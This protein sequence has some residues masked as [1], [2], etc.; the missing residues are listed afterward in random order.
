V[1]AGALVTPLGSAGR[2]RLWNAPFALISGVLLALAE[3]LLH[4]TILLVFFVSQLTDSL[5]TIG[6]VVTVGLLGWYLP[7][8][9]VPWLSQSSARQMPWALSASLVRAAAAIFLAYSGYR[10]DVTDDDRLRS[11]FICYIVY[12]VAAGFAQSPVNELIA[13]SIPAESRARIF[14]QRALWAGIF[15]VGAGVL[16]RQTISTD[17]PGFPRNFALIFIAAAAAASGAALFVGRIREPRTLQRTGPARFTPRATDFMRVLSDGAFRRFILFGVFAGISTA[18][19]AFYVIYARREFDIPPSWIG[20]FLGLFAATALL[21]TPLW[22]GI[23]RLSGARGALQTAMALRV[24]SPLTMVGLPYA[25]DSDL[26][27]DNVS[28][29]RIIFYILAVPIAI[30]GLTARGLAIGNFRYVMDLSV[31][32][33]RSAYQMLALTPMLVAA[34][35]PIA[36]AEIADRW[37]FDRLFLVALFAGFV[38]VLFTGLLAGTGRRVRASSAAWRLKEARS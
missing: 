10:T 36:G 4:P 17:G 33:R 30:F 1:P 23:V 19:D 7:Q 29:E 5:R 24:V 3:A 9:I 12:S 8:L 28:N 27:R 13:R 15:A 6:L 16:A 32:E 11:F 22:A 31:G 34:A 18:A 21:S 37:G 38:S 26:Y 2:L 20:A 35:A 14:Q 25:L